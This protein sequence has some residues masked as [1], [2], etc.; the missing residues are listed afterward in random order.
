[1]AISTRLKQAAIFPMLLRSTLQREPIEVIETR[2]YGTFADANDSTYFGAL[3]PK[4]SSLVCRQAFRFGKPAELWLSARFGGGDELR[5]PSEAVPASER[6]FELGGLVFTRRRSGSWGIA[7]DGPLVQAGKQ[8]SAKVDLEF[9]GTSRVI[10]F[11]DAKDDWGVALAVAKEP[12]S[13]TFFEKVGELKQNHIEQAGRITGSVVIDGERHDLDWPAVRDH[14]NGRRRWETSTRHGWLCGVLDDGRALC[15][16][17]AKYDFISEMLAG[18]VTEGGR[19]DAIVESEHLSTVA[20]RPGMREHACR[21]RTRS[22]REYTLTTKFEHRHCFD[23]DDV[24]RIDEGMADF[25]LDGAHGRGV[26]EFG[27]NRASFPEAF[28]LTPTEA[29]A[30]GSSAPRASRSHGAKAEAG[31]ARGAAT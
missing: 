2:T 15:V 9:K 6:G 25:D 7:Y 4:G 21:F 16:A 24:Y 18:Y 30:T 29:S 27:W 28:A 12:W 13:R 10:D 23:M 26:D 8:R 22:G 1:M 11:R 19:V 17:R 5:V 31:A 3:G 14:S 20:P